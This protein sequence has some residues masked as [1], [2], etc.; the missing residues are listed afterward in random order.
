MYAMNVSRIVTLYGNGCSGLLMYPCAC[1]CR[2]NGSHLIS[3]Q[4]RWYRFHPVV[5]PLAE[6]ADTRSWARYCQL[7]CNRSHNCRSVSCFAGVWIAVIVPGGLFAW[8]R[9]SCLSLSCSTYCLV[10][11]PAFV[12]PT[13]VGCCWLL[14]V[15][16]R[17]HS[18]GVARCSRSSPY[19]QDIYGQTM[20][21]SCLK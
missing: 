16:S 12:L 13:D 2:N 19:L 6:L 17:A 11:D 7:C 1:W 20:L 15:S 10:A 9:F 5:Y 8:I 3:L 18:A 21:D 14:L 4:N